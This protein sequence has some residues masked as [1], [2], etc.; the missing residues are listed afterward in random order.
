MHINGQ[1]IR[2]SANCV[3]RIVGDLLGVYFLRFH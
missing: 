2:H 1:D 3:R